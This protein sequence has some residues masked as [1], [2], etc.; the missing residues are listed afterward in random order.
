ML[1]KNPCKVQRRVEKEYAIWF[2][3]FNELGKK[4]EAAQYL[5]C[6]PSL[7]TEQKMKSEC[8]ADFQ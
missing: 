6:F 2:N 5:L 4:W 1:Y 3:C 8:V 7:I